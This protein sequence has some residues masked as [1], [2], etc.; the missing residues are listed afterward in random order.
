MINPL[1]LISDTVKNN[2]NID[3][4]TE[5]SIE[6]VDPHV[7]LTTERIDL[8]AKLIYIESFI[9]NKDMDI[10]DSI[11]K[12]HI[13]AFSLGE[14]IEPGDSNKESYEDF[15]SAFNQLIYSFQCCGFNDKESLIPVGDNNV[16]LDGAHRTA[17]AIYFNTKV[18]IIRFKGIKVLF[19]YHFF[20]DRYLNQYYLQ[21][22]AET[23]SRYASSNVYCCI[24]WPAAKKNKRKEAF[25]ILEKEIGH[26]LLVSSVHFSI[27]SLRELMTIIYANQKWIGS[28]EDGFS[29]V[30]GKVKECY[31][32]GAESELILFEANGLADVIHVKEKMRNVF[33]I[34]KHSL[35]ISDNNDETILIEQFVFHSE[36]LKSKV[37]D[38]RATTHWRIEACILMFKRFLRRL[39]LE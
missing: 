18:T 9:E 6:V 32:P 33:G 39:F 26:I 14:Y 11:Y 34:G 24:I 29:G 10:A 23:W 30:M 31:K 22:M 16:I 3:D 25:S 17:C 36:P 21:R 20:S 15:V 28:S 12:R 38:F 37:Q 1:S 7:L 4:S 8:G 5:F 35:H 2:W 19:D 27:T 13:E